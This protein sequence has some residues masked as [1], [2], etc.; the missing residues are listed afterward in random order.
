MLY[1][2][3]L[4][5]IGLVCLLGLTGV[6]VGIAGGGTTA[7]PTVGVLKVVATGGNAPGMSRLGEIGTVKGELQDASGNRV[8]S[9]LWRCQY[10]GGKATSSEPNLFCRFT[11]TFGSRGSI[12]T[13]G[14]VAGYYNGAQWNAI[15][16]G[17]GAYRNA[18]GVVRFT[19]L[20]TSA[21]PHTYYLIK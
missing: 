13:S 7:A 3:W 12:I 20:A 11:A 5:R 2:R 1:R 10:L 17:T 19:S 21:T 9:W 8:G 15:I 16:G 14:G 6:G 4:F 18:V